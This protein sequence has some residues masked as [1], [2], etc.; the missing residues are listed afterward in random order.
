MPDGVST[1]G[2]VGPL[3]E[4]V[5]ASPGSPLRPSMRYETLNAQAGRVPVVAMVSAPLPASVSAVMVS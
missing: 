2:V 3:A 4:M 1:T 5:T